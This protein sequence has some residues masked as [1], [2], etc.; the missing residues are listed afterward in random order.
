MKFEN[1]ITV[2]TN[3]PLL[4]LGRFEGVGKKLSYS[5]H[6]DVQGYDG[7]RIAKVYMNSQPPRELQ[8]RLGMPK[9][10]T[11]SAQLTNENELKR[12]LHSISH[13]NNN[14]LNQ[15]KPRG[16]NMKTLIIR[17]IT[18]LVSLI[19]LSFVNAGIVSIIPIVGITTIFGRKSNDDT[20]NRLPEAYQGIRSN[21]PREQY[22]A[23]QVEQ[24][25][26]QEAYRDKVNQVISEAKEQWDK[27][28]PAFSEIQ[29]LIA[30]ND[31][32]DLVEAYERDNLQSTEAIVNTL[33][34][35]IDK[36]GEKSN[37]GIYIDQTVGQFTHKVMGEHCLD[38]HVDHI[39][40][41]LD[42]ILNIQ[43]Q[44]NVN[45]KKF[46]EDDLP[47]EDED[48]SPSGTRPTDSSDQSEMDVLTTDFYTAFINP[49]CGNVGCD[50]C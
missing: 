48:E 35:I 27:D 50:I 23:E 15:H 43:S 22:I 38:C 8:T 16:N 5:Y 29:S 17:V 39:S 25:D 47:K 40:D 20:A 2:F 4:S 49:T 33:F 36:E 7:D 10:R 13:S 31:Y 46:H 9:A 18:A 3:L 44:Y 45:F 34:V 11:V 21:T 1:Y 14:N 37:D 32:C 26:P 30:D 6:M 12:P 41:I 28:N 24:V 19:I 42:Q